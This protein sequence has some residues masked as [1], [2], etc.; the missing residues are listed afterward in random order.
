VI[1]D[2]LIF[3]PRNY[4]PVLQVKRFDTKFGPLVGSQIY[5]LLT[6]FFTWSGGEGLHGGRALLWLVGLAEHTS[7][8][9]SQVSPGRDKP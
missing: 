1:P 5:Y 6:P 3:E 9:C 4:S 2:I 7:S 8:Y